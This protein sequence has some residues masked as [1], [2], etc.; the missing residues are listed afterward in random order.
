MSKTKKSCFVISPIGEEGSDTRK[1]S[2]QVLNHII[3]P[4]ALECD[5]IAVRADEIDKP[6]LITSQ[7][8]Q[9]VVSDDLVIADLTETNPNVFYE[10]AV[11]HAFKKPFVQIIKK[12]ERIPFDVA[13][14]RTIYFDHKDLD[15]VQETKEAIKRQILEIEKGGEVETPISVSEEL[16]S[17]RQ[18]DNP[19]DRGRAEIIGEMSQL[20][21]VLSNIQEMIV[22]DKS[23]SKNRESEVDFELSRRNYSRIQFR[24]TRNLI[25]EIR[26]MENKSL[27]FIIICSA[28]INTHPWVFNLAEQL[29]FAIIN[30]NS[31]YASDIFNALNLYI[32]N[33]ASKNE[34]ESFHTFHMISNYLTN[35]VLD[36]ARSVGVGIDDEI[37]F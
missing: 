15:S 11:R 37:P 1:R 34:E 31:K 35:D 8:I 23:R 18:S 5:Y 21:S 19:E 36:Y 20:R 6:G 3:K 4:V 7:V 26:R 24:K 22:E 13:G 2:D 10:L 32:L 25:E 14:T 12:G 28:L 16:Q 30:R 9:R 17:L 33:N 29:N 27:G